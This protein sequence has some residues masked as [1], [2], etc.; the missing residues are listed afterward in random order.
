VSEANKEHKDMN[1]YALAIGQIVVNLQMLELLLR[2]RLYHEDSPRSVLPS[3][4]EATLLRELS[5]GEEAILDSLTS[6]E[7]FGELITCYNGQLPPT[8]TVNEDAARSSASAVGHRD[9]RCA[10]IAARSPSG[11]FTGPHQR[12]GP[13][14]CLPATARVPSRS[15]AH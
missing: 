1:R 12:V 2:V 11:S 5:V 9:E 10:P 13:W 4:I 8:E 15:A 7:S 14:R 3:E 6:Y